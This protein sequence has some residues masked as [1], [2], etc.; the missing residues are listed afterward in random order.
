ME[1]EELIKTD[2]NMIAELG[3]D[4]YWNHNNCYYPYLLKQLPKQCQCGLDIGCGK[5]ELTALLAK[6]V[7]QVIAVDLADKMID[8]A[9]DH[10][11]ADNITYICGNILEMDYAPST[12]DVIISSATAHHL[13]YDWLLEFAREKLRSGGKLIILDLFKAETPIDYA[14][15]IIA[16]VPNVVLN[17][18]RNGHLHKDDHQAAEVWRRHQTHDRY[19]SLQEIRLLV[20]RYLPGASVRRKLFWRYTLIWEKD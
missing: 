7:K 8:D 19:M 15:S 5:G 10:N 11:S 1:D 6:T 14:I 3:K 12:F 13:P 9:Q 16:V 2:F 20:S 4:P 18:L 17:L